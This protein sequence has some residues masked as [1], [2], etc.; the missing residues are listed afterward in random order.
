M[1]TQVFVLYKRDGNTKESRKI[2]F[3]EYGHHISLYYPKLYMEL[4]HLT[5]PAEFLSH[6]R[7]PPEGNAAAVVLSPLLW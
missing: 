3:G 7:T 6:A 1:T 4:Q 5:M 2:N